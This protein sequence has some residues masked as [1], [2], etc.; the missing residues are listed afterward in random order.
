MSRIEVSFKS[1]VGGGDKFFGA[2]NTRIGKIAGSIAKSVAAAD[3]KLFFVLFFHHRLFND[4]ALTGFRAVNR[5]GF[6]KVAAISSQPLF[7]EKVGFQRH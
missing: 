2:D 4:L 1:L 7:A 3:I 6:I 5:T